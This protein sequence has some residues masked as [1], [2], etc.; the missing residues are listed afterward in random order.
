MSGVGSNFIVTAGNPH[1]VTYTGSSPM[2]A[3][4][5]VNG[6]QFY[7]VNVDVRVAILKN[8]I[9]SFSGSAPYMQGVTGGGAGMFSVNQILI[10]NSGDYFQAGVWT[11]NQRTSQ[12]VNSTFQIA[13]TK[14]VY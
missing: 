13:I 5:D 3:K 12:F 4:V 1:R 14:L 2:Y 7:N 10:I 9:T 11:S 6:T 8:G